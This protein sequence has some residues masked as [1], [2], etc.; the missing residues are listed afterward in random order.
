MNIWNHPNEGIC[1]SSALEGFRFVMICLNLSGI[2]TG[3]RNN[4]DKTRENVPGAVP[5]QGE[6]QDCEGN[7]DET[8]G[9]LFPAPT[10]PLLNHLQIAPLRWKGYNFPNNFPN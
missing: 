2:R 1:I 8:Q 9:I 10:Q 5:G 7:R 4:L 6:G 3:E